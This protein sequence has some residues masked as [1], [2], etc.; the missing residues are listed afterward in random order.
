MRDLIRLCNKDG[1]VK[2]QLTDLSTARERDHRRPRLSDQS[3]GR[4][5]SEN[6]GEEVGGTVGGVIVGHSRLVLNLSC[7]RG[8]HFFSMTPMVSPRA[9]T[10]VC[11]RRV[12]VNGFCPCHGR[13]SSTVQGWVNQAT[14]GRRS[15][16]G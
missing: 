2:Q 12:V 7:R 8:H 15:E 3:F 1:E 6:L 14:H 16:H 10:S 5:R 11:G 4:A 9:I 13:A